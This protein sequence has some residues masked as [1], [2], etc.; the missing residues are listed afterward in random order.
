MTLSTSCGENTGTLFWKTTDAAPFTTM[1][2]RDL[3]LSGEPL[4][5]RL[6]G[7]G[8][9]S[10]LWLRIDLDRPLA[11]TCWGPAELRVSREIGVCRLPFRHA[12]EIGKAGLEV[13]ADH[14]VHVDEDPHDLRDEGLGPCMVHV[15]LVAPPAGCSV[16][17]VML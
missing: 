3:K 1:R 14:L 4:P 5:V 17:S 6:S 2:S 11:V 16:N 8:S 13:L 9:P 7:L 10:K 15:T 12:L